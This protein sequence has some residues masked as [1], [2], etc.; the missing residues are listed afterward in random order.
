M[1][2]G[3]SAEGQCDRLQIKENQGVDAAGRPQVAAERASSRF[4]RADIGDGGAHTA[5][6]DAE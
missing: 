1:T 2:A 6:T 5:S 3:G 4:N